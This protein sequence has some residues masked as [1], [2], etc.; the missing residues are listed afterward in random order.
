MHAKHKNS[1]KTGDSLSPPKVR[2]EPTPKN[3]VDFS[4]KTGDSAEYRVYWE[5]E[6]EY[7]STVTKKK[8]G[9]GIGARMI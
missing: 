8:L 2:R 9:L 6:Y 7:W 3:N 1:A 5:Y 4:A